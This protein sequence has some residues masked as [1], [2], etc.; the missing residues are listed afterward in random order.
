MPQSEL[1][2]KDRGFYA[3]GTVMLRVDIRFSQDSD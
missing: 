1:L 2:D 3:D